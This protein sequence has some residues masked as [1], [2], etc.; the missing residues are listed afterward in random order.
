MAGNYA[1]VADDD[2]GLQIIDITN[3]SS[4][5]LSGS[6]DTPGYAVNTAISGNKVYVSDGYSGLQ[7]ININDP[8]LPVLE[9]NYDTPNSALGVN[10]L[11]GYAY[12]ADHNSGLQIINVATPLIPVL[13]GNYDTPGMAYDIALSDNYI[14]I[15]DVYGIIILRV[16]DVDCCNGLTGNVDCSA[17]EDPDITDITRIID[18]LY[19]SH[20]PLSPCQ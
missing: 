2:A 15:A 9:G 14:Y 11:N 12:V 19:L 8:K 18:F 4:P 16:E 1:Y 17:G 7:I 13:A 5:V 6:Y 10:I 20:S 3:P